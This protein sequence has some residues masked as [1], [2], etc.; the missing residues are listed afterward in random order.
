[1]NS[2]ESRLPSFS[3][4]TRSFAEPPPESG[5]ALTSSRSRRDAVDVTAHELENARQLVQDSDRELAKQYALTLAFHETSNEPAADFDPSKM[6]VN[7][8]PPYS[9]FGRAWK[10]FNDALKAEPFATFA[11]NNTIN[12]QN[13]TWTPSSASLDFEIRGAS[14]H[15]SKYTPGWEAASA[16]VAAAARALEPSAEHSFAHTGEHSAPLALIGDFYGH[17]A[18]STKSQ[19]S[20]SIEQLLTQ[21]SF[22][23]L[24]PAN[25]NSLQ[26]A[27]IVEQQHQTAEV[28]AKEPASVPLEQ[29]PSAQVDE[30]DRELAQ[31][32]ATALLTLRKETRPAAA[33]PPARRLFLELPPLSTLAQTFKAFNEALS[34][35]A[36]LDFV[37]K[38]NL[39]V[40][41]LRVD[42]TTGNLLARSPK[43]SDAP[44]KM[45]TRDDSSGW[46]QVA[47]AIVALAKKLSAGTGALVPCFNV[48]TA[49]LG[50]VLSF[51]GEPPADPSL[52]GVLKQS[53]ALNR[54]G[55]SALT[56]AAHD[57]RSREVKQNQLAVKQQL[58][59]QAAADKPITIPPRRSPTAEIARQQFAGEPGLQ[60]V[61]GRL[62]TDAI[63]SAS[64]G[65]DFD[66]NQ[67]DLAQPDPDNPGQFKRKPLT[68]LALEY[69]VDGAVP[70][71]PANSKLVDTRPDVLTH[72]GNTPDTP[73][74]VDMGA[75]Q[76]AFRALPGQ[77]AQAL[78]TDVSNYWDQPAFGAPT[79]ASLSPF[80]GSRRTL[81]SNLLRDNL[82]LAALKQPGLDDLQRE[83]LD[84]V[85][86]YPNGSTRPSSNDNAEV[87][88]FNLGSISEPNQGAIESTSA[89][90]LIQRHVGE[91]TILL[92]CEPSGKVTPYDSYAAFNAARERQLKAQAPEQRLLNTLRK[93]DGNAFQ[94]QAETVITQRLD[95]SLAPDPSWLNLDTLDQ[96]SRKMPSWV[97]NAT[98]AERV[99]LRE[100]SLQLASITQ[101]NKGRTYNSDIP[102]IRPFAEQAFDQLK[103]VSHPAKNL[104]VVFKVP[105][106]GN[107]PGGVVS[108][109]L[110]RERMSMTDVLLK[111]L[112]GLP[113]RD[114]EVYLK[115]GNTRVPE[116]EK[117]GELQKLIEKVDVGKSYPELLKRELLDDPVKKAQRQ[118]LF[119]QQVPVE[120]QIKALELAVNKQSGFDTTG[121]R[122]VQAAVNP[123]PGAQT[124]DGKE[125]VVR[126]L[127]FIAGPGATPEVVDNMYLIEPEDSSGGPHILYRPLIADAPLLQFP[128]RQALLEAIQQPGRLQNDILAWF[129]DNATRDYY[130]AWSFKEPSTQ[131]TSLF[132]VGD[133]ETVPAAP[134]LAVGGYAAADA[135]KAKLQTGQLMNHLYDANAQGLISMAEQQSVSDAESRWATLK[136][137]GYLLLN[138]VLPALRGP[139]AAIGTA[140]QFQGILS[141]LQTLADNATPDKETAMADLLLNFAML[142]THSRARSSR[143]P[144]DPPPT[145]E[146]TQ[147]ALRSGSHNS[148]IEA[149]NG[150]KVR[151]LIVMKGNM[152]KMQLIKGNL[153]SF[154][155]EYKGKPR[156]NINAHGRDLS[157]REQ[158]SG[159]SSTILY[160]GAEHTAEQ[161]HAHLLAKGIDPSQFDN[162]R[163]LV[164]YSGN[165]AE[166]SFAAEF[167]RLI[168]K[169]VKAF[170][171]TVTVT[172]SPELVTA[173]FKTGIQMHG[174]Q[175]GPKL[176][177]DTYAQYDSVDTVKD[178]TGISLIRNP[179]EYILFSYYPVYFPPRT[180]ATAANR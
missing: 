147:A 59:Q 78:T 17:D 31:N 62:L 163:L 26:A 138:A 143:R 110:H 79:R 8:I 28:L 45:F 42:P 89:N 16:D 93:V 37:E 116:L 177:S 139:G 40:A 56:S 54:N 85:V 123:Q 13:F 109:S 160:D 87:T 2:I 57:P 104:E 152:Q 137:G 126:P 5:A 179:L 133:G 27:H 71:L 149:P 20:A 169:P 64:P 11:K 168:N 4:A 82:R 14:G 97:S 173:E 145:P 172:P 6:T 130:K 150:E 158:L 114:V 81:I 47:P 176:V 144:V 131:T 34:S 63:K 66:I 43:G 92:L 60:A 122:Y 178:R 99:V 70:D 86:R 161:L 115:P 101:R 39:V 102:D 36:F 166:N 15:F 83:T 127:A 88:V 96:P 80:A 108:G 38:N 53:S 134:T 73:L 146:V 48:E 165:G 107:S 129:P 68:T 67:V 18:Y 69:L 135:L 111:N 3:N 22:P 90:L 162:V 25:T 170:V 12:T 153:F 74:A 72:T 148:I 84:L 132:G 94:T 142:V 41:N 154:E 174:T 180:G 156:L 44:P 58:D 119:A 167:Q 112:S 91:R 51:Y 9:T 32:T 10:K 1:M 155:D 50:Q 113:S 175:K 77:L 159:K 19:R 157:F 75:I 124:V 136:E 105:V 52:Q 171:G 7:N 61:V 151:R 128:T 49:S 140:L 121:L 141:D 21:Q 118:S 46:A 76:S 95:N 100:L 117:D 35:E 23:S 106:G 120:L 65:L 24:L 164:C 33:L 103:A 30:A 98:E 125:I 55:F 29:T